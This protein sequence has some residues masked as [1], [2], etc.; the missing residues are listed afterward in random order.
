MYC[1][2]CGTHLEEINGTHCP[3]CA[4][5][6][7]ARRKRSS[8]SL[9]EPLSEKSSEKKA[10]SRRSF[11]LFAGLLIVVSIFLILFLPKFFHDGDSETP[12]ALPFQTIDAAFYQRVKVDID[13][14]SVSDGKANVRITLPD[15][16]KIVDAL[17]SEQPDL[18]ETEFFE[19]ILAQMDRHVLEK[20]FI[21]GVTQNHGQWEL[22]SSEEID[23][24]L[25]ETLDEFLLHYLMQMEF[26]AMEGEVNP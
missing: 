8:E 3:H 19:E 15:L 6:I 22:S 1:T 14:S 7:H 13:Q 2:N 9:A 12:E 5:P 10:R 21:M 23:R 26:E 16:V 25:G 24:V 11:L 4:H 18:S 20:E 17:M